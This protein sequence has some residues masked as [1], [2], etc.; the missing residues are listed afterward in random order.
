VDDALPNVA[1]ASDVSGNSESGFTVIVVVL[2]TEF[3]T[4]LAAAATSASAIVSCS[5]VSASTVLPP[6]VSAARPTFAATLAPV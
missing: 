4:E 6:S 5:T 3:S 2:V 1:L